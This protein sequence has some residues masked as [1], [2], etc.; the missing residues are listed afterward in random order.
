M[1]GR[2]LS[3]HTQSGTDHFSSCGFFRPIP[4]GRG[5][6]T[7]NFAVFAGRQWLYLCA[8]L[9]LS[10]LLHSNSLTAATALQQ[11]DGRDICAGKTVLFVTGSI[12]LPSS[13]QAVFD[14]LLSRS[15]FITIVDDET[16]N[17]SDAAGADL[18]IISESVFSVNV[19]DVFRNVATP[20]L[21]WEAFL[22]DDLGMAGPVE[23][24]DYGEVTDQTSLFMVNDLHPL[25]AGL[26]GLVQT[27]SE[28]KR[29]QWG[30]PAA[31]AIHIATLENEPTK[32]AIFAY[33]A[34]T[35]MLDSSAP[36]TRI[37]M[38]S[39]SA[40]TAD[41]WSLF[42]AA[43]TW[44]LA[45]G[46]VNPAPTATPTPFPTQTTI[47][48]PSGTYTLSV[49]VDGSGT[50]VVDPNKPFYSS[51]E[52][53]RLQARPEPGWKFAGWKGPTITNLN[54]TIVLITNESLTIVA[55]FE[56]DTVATATLIPTP[57]V[58][59]TSTPIPTATEIPT[60]TLVP[61]DTPT[62]LPTN[63][64]IA[65]TSVPTATSVHTNTLEPT[66]TQLP[67]ATPTP[68]PTALPTST[69]Q[70][71]PAA[72][73]TP[74]A[75]PT[76][77]MTPTTAA[78]ET[79][80]DIPPPAVLS[81]SLS[82]TLLVDS[83]DDGNAGP[84]D[85]I[86]YLAIV[87]NTGGSEAH[88]VVFNLVPDQNVSLIHESVQSTAGEIVLG[89]AANDIQIVIGL[90]TLGQGETAEISFDISVPANLE[91]GVNE[92]RSQ[93][94]IAG[95]GLTRVVTD[96]PDT[97]APYDETIVVLKNEL[98]INVSYKDVLLVDEDDDRQFSVGDTLVYIIWVENLGNRQVNRLQVETKPDANLRLINGSV[99]VSQGTVLAGNGEGQDT[100]H[101]EIEILDIN[102]LEWVRFQAQIT[103]ANLE[104]Q[105]VNQAIVSFSRVVGATEVDQVLSDDPD[106]PGEIGDPT[107]TVVH[108]ADSMD[109]Y[110][111]PVVTQ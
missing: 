54:P 40:F 24:V 21:T 58:T 28:P 25:G 65:T 83:D 95:A 38:H 47:A 111:L 9:M 108:G 82:D 53:I 36:A 7:V 61:S 75:L 34:G 13:D 91:A 63:T 37:G 84:G 66:A 88:H 16:V 73:P 5:K 4:D 109:T 46:V 70:P 98:R 26:S 6:R 41:G 72:T 39:V 19:G 32:T 90:G 87:E 43:T 81:A 31:N 69:Q 45:C 110:Y 1:F 96:D 89:N 14:R 94:T 77:T 52:L 10:H 68:M 74:T 17:L 106:T 79:P 62:S 33:D 49:I 15:L 93:G 101:A 97:V 29:F 3:R 86:R 18:I 105:L 56:P 22:Y 99:E 27:H 102:G 20:L 64:A 51:G 59:S 23:E 60:E 107:I 8:I 2:R 12:P 44:A 85:L 50:V 100:I 92:I 80:T 104:G 103:G 30:R 78:T 76:E 35:Q 42:D 11:D 55:S 71:T 57:S 67:P 48:T